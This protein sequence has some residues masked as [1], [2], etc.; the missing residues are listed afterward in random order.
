MIGLS[1]GSRFIFSQERKAH[2]GISYSHLSLSDLVQ[3]CHLR[4]QSSGLVYLFEGNLK[5]HLFID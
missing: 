5:I 4:W 3:S 2:T 1:E